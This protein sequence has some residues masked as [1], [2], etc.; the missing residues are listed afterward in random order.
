M[1]KLTLEDLQFGKVAL[2]FKPCA[3]LADRDSDA[4]DDDV[5]YNSGT[6]TADVWMVANQFRFFLSTRLFILNEII[7]INGIGS[8][9]AFIIPIPPR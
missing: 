9:L 8:T 3:A 7:Q 4:D 1:R 2:V 5:L 6:D